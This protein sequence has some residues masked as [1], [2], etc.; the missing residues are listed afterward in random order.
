MCAKEGGRFPADFKEDWGLQG[1][2]DFRVHPNV[3]LLSDIRYAD[4]GNISVFSAIP[5]IKFHSSDASHSIAIRLISISPSD[6]GTKFGAS[7]HYDRKFDERFRLFGGVAS[8][9]DTEAGLT[10]QLRSVFGGASLVLADTVSMI[11]TGEYDRRE[12]SYT[13][14]A[15]NLALIFRLAD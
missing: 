10:R 11:V 6:S 8:Y 14:K 13:R 5:G 15:I 4:Y 9:P 2:A 1:G 7:A 3:T 12:R